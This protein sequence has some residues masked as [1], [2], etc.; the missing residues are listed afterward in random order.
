MQMTEL[1]F[2]CLVVTT[3]DNVREPVGIVTDKDLRRRCIA[4]GL[5]YNLPVSDIMTDNMLTIQAGSR[6]Y[7]ALMLMTA[8]RIHHLP[9]MEGGNLL[10]MVT[11]TDLMN[12]ESPKCGEFNAYYS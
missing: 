3:D 9:V 7:D 10:A 5:D 11:I 1:G 2:S 6:A 8:K 4:Q 12:H